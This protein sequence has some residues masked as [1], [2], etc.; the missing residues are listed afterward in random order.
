MFLF[1]TT[2]FANRWNIV[3]LYLLSALV[4]L[5]QIRLYDWGGAGLAT[6]YVYMSSTSRKRGDRV[7]GYWRAWELWVYAYFPILAPEPEVEMSPVVPYSY[8]Y[9]GRCLRRTRETFSF[10]CRYFDRVITGEITWQPWAL[11]SAGVRD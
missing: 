8:R 1:S 2:L 11:M 10:F 7:G 5:S 4:D 6:L 3:G 9:D